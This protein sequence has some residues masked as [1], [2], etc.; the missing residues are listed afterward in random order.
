MDKQNDKE[1]FSFTYSAKQMDEIKHIRDKYLPKE[2]DKLEQL[3][4]LDRSVTQKG[5]VVS[6]IVGILGTLIMGAGM[7]LTLVWT[8]EWLVLGIIVGA[9]G[10][11]VLSVAYPLYSSIIK[12]ERHKIAPE[13]MRL[14]DEL[15]K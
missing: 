12:K 2:A 6:L 10:M 9:V 3:R 15:M 1:G 8:E 7:S 13:I 14:T 4:Q 11:A 5:T